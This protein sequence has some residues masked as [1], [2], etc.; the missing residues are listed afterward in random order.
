MFLP[1]QLYKHSIWTAE[2]GSTPGVKCD[3]SQALRA[4]WCYH[5]IVRACEKN[6]F[7]AHCISVAF[8]DMTSDIFTFTV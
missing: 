2:D 8:S 6:W 5:C 3:L 4:T 7:M 1:N